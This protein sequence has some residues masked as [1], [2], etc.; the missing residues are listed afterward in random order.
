MARVRLPGFVGPSYTSESRIAAY[1][2]T[3]NLIPEKIES[4]TGQADFVLYLAPGYKTFCT[5]P[6]TPVRG[7]FT[8]NGTSW[9]VGG[10]SLYQLP[11]TSGGSPTL[12]T[13]GVTNPDDGWVT[14]AGNGDAGHQLLLSSGSFTFCFDLQT[15]TLTTVGI[16]QQVGFLNAYGI[17]LN[18]AR[19]EFA[20][21]A[22]EDFS[23]WDPLDVNQRSD[24]PDKWV[25]LLVQQS[26]KEMWLFGTETTSVYY[27]VEDPVT[28]FVP[29]PSVFLTVGIAAPQSAC[30]LK[31]API[32]LGQ[33]KDGQGIVY[34]ANGYTPTRVSTHA[35]ELAF[36]SYNLATARAIVYEER[37]HSFYVLT[38]PPVSVYGEPVV[39]GATWVFDATTGFW[40]ERGLWNGWTYEAVPTIGHILANGVHL[41]GSPTSGVIYQMSKDLL[42]DTAGNGQRWLRRAP[43]VAANRR[44]LIIDRVEL[45]LEVGL[46]LP[47]GQGSN[48]RVSW[49]ASANGGETWGVA[50]EVTA[51]RT[52]AFGTRAEWRQF[53]IGLDWVHEATGTD[54]IAWRLVD[55]FLDVRSESS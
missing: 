54:P 24:A 26:G 47:S 32:W 23:S 39:L 34:W 12:L 27:N 43:H 31:G 17:A 53:G 1:D 3:V 25:A 4:G 51:G 38:F 29:N 16:G 42:T 13:T 9:A 52:G 28:P 8:L 46:G 49:Q 10:E 6:D 11:T 21:S 35:V 15:N 40:H 5:L 45:L 55:A 41:V 37:G 50:R 20:L 7:L 18:T 22:L 14:I 48:P 33:S 44:R 36:A 2:R 30:V 19:S